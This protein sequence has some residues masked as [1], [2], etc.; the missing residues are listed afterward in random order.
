M[1]PSFDLI[2]NK[3]IE[4]GF[5]D[6]GI[7]KA[8]IPESDVKAYLEWIKSGFHGDL[9]YM[10]NSVRCDPEQILPGAKTAIIFVSYYKQEKISFKKESGV[11]AS[12]A[13]GR[14]Y[15]HV[16][17]KRLKKF[18]TWLEEVTQETHIAKSFS[19]STPVLEKALA[20][21]AGLGWFGKNS[22]LI[23]RR[24]GTFILLSGI[25]TTLTIENPTM[26]LSLPRCGSCQRC[27]DACPTNAIIEPYKVNATR[28]LSYHLIESKAEIPEAIQKRNPGYIFGCDICQ[29]VC[30]HNVRKPLSEHQEFSPE[31]GIGPEINRD[32]LNELEVN[33][34]LLF[35][36]PLQRRKVLG[37]KKTA[38]SL[39][40]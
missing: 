8:K 26:N 12:Y 11:V 5:D 25:F 21:Q 6:V 13:R 35:G 37:L 30:P 24:F 14:D 16:H 29:D 4:L 15:H 10:E 39:S 7:T 18:V 2:K 9:S 33:P 22:L 27:M 20:V 17:K 3:A 1:I 34:E 31:S 36:T 28:C 32:L 23:H 40:L 19:D 38:L